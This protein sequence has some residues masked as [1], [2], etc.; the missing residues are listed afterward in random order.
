MDQ[1]YFYIYLFKVQITDTANNSYDIECNICNVNDGGCSWYH[2]KHFRRRVFTQS[3]VF[4]YVLVGVFFIAGLF[5]P[6]ELTDLFWGVLYFICIPAGYLFLI[7]YAIC[8]LNNVSWGTRETQKAV[9][10]CQTQGTHKKKKT[11]EEFG[12]VS[13]EVIEDILKQVKSRK[14]QDSPCLDLV[15]SIFQWI[16]NFVILRSLESVVSIFKNT[17][18]DDEIVKA[19]G[20]SLCRNQW[21]GQ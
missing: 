19:D 21:D 11:E 7:I 3:A 18:A 15:P 4:M 20:R 16:N 9:L 13:V 10:E 12:I 8:N 1:Q 6:H 5:H 17:V 2:C 14:N